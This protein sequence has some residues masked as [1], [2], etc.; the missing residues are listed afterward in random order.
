MSEA[1]FSQNQR[2]QFTTFYVDGELFGIDVLR[3][4]E[5]TGTPQVQGVPLSPPFVLG[6]VNLRGQIATA[7]G[8]REVFSKP[9]KANS[10]P[11]S[12]VCKLEGNLISLLVDSIGEVVELEK[13]EF[14]TPPDTIPPQIRKFIK[15]I[16]KMNGGLMSVLDLDTLAKE[17][18]PTGETASTKS[19]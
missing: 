2:S 17:L 6:L 8:L 7:L 10:S 19:H 12:V 4:Q 1:S 16:Y 5:V 15:G 13:S 3:V 18:S 9:S 14:E 11:M